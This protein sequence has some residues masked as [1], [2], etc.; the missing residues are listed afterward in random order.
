M[1]HPKL[2]EILD[3]VNGSETVSVTHAIFDAEGNLVD[4]VL[5]WRGL[6]EYVPVSKSQKMDKF[7]V[8][9][10]FTSQRGGICIMCEEVNQ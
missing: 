8:L 3:V 2:K 10:I 5:V 6:P 1:N 7:V 4:Q 9:N